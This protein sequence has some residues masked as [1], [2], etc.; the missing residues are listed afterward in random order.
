MIYFK[1]NCDHSETAV[2]A[3]TS[4]RPTRTLVMGIKKK[5]DFSVGPETP[6]LLRLW[7]LALVPYWRSQLLINSLNVVLKG[8]VGLIV[9]LLVELGFLDAGKVLAV[10]V[11]AVP[12]FE[13]IFAHALEQALE[14]GVT[15]VV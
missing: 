8:T 3:F 1:Q 10:L 11:R 14:L 4:P 5:G 2:S 12:R 15:W 7:L 13:A 9:L 6:R